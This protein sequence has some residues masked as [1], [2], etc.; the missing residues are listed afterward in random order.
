MKGQGSAQEP[1]VTD[2]ETED[3]RLRFRV[4]DGLMPDKQFDRR[5]AMLQV[6]R[7]RPKYENDKSPSIPPPAVV[8]IHGRTVPGPVLFD[9]RDPA[10]GGIDLNLSLQKA[11][12]WEGID[13]FAPNLLGYGRSTRFDE[14]LND[15]G[16]ASLRACPTDG[17]RPPPEGCDSTLNERINPLDQQGQRDPTLLWVN[18]L[19]GRRR[20]HSSNF[21]FARTDVWV[22][23][24]DHVICD[25]INKN[26]EEYPGSGAGSDQ[27][28]V[29]LVGYSLGGQHVGRTLY[30]NTPP[31]NEPED[32]LGDLDREDII[33]KVSRVVFVN[34]LFGGPIEEADPFTPPAFPLTVNG[35][36]GSDALWRPVGISAEDCPGRVIPG[37]QAQVWTQTMEQETVGREWG[38][39]DPT[40]PTGLNRAP[41][42]SGYGWTPTVAGQLSKPTLV[43][44][45]LNDGT[46]PTGLFPGQAGPLTGRAIYDA[47]YKA[48][49][50]DDSLP[51]KVLVEVQ[52]AS[53]ALVWE[54]CGQGLATLPA[55]CTPPRGFKPYGQKEHE[56]WAG[57]HSTLKAALIEW[58]KHR[59]FNDVESAS[60]IVNE[61]GVVVNESGV[62]SATS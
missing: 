44:Q 40:R 25:A 59:K 31:N 37:T 52:C 41:T 28:Q 53:H 29:V 26:I 47:L 50:Q 22:R 10:T 8:L 32:L 49:P 12:A 18:P 38:G 36:P 34:S 24:I 13:T 6:H 57:P 46:L 62:A 1:K 2:V 5:P 51:K 61:S 19:G 48:L 7:V 17:T 21:R 15:P 9:L 33:N 45:G 55:R 3:Y 16:N 54:G 56:P 30:A 4:P 60:Y 42:F 20:A 35:R 11:L 58:I 43:I 23:D 39:D 27:R 14:G